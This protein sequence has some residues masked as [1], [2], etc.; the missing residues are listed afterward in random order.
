MRMY[1]FITLILSLSSLGYSQYG[2][3]QNGYPQNDNVP[4]GYSMNAETSL[5][6]SGYGLRYPNELL[7][8]FFPIWSLVL[9]SMAG[10]KFKKIIIK[11]HLKI[12][13]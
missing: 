10:W 6:R 5:D 13:N 2:Y 7:S 1:L 9:I 3:D 12:T 4:N 11:S 8:G